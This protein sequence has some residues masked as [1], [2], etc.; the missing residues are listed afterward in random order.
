MWGGVHHHF[1]SKNGRAGAFFQISFTRESQWVG[2]SSPSNYQCIALE[3]GAHSKKAPEPG[4]HS[5]KAPES[6]QQKQVYSG[7]S[8]GVCP[9]RY[10]FQLLIVLPHLLK[11]QANTLQSILSLIHLLTARCTRAFLVPSF[12]SILSLYHLL[13]CVVGEVAPSAQSTVVQ[14]CLRD[15][16]LAFQNR[17]RDQKEQN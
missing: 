16:F 4:S 17:Q 3:P 15:Q 12:I 7:L 1:L 10:I 2:F 13:P 9:L 14:W 6:S 11:K 5:K 8:K